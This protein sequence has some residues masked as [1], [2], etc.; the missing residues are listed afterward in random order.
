[1]LFR[2]GVRVMVLAID[3][4]S[5]GEEGEEFKGCNLAEIEGL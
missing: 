4:I 3:V 5:N 1:M 2:I